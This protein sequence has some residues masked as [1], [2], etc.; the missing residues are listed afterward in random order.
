MN[1]NI[2][3]SGLSFFDEASSQ[4][5]FLPT[6]SFPSYSSTAETM[7]SVQGATKNTLLISNV[8]SRRNAITLRLLT[9]ATIWCM[10]WDSTRKAI[11]ALTDTSALVLSSE[12]GAVLVETS[13][14][15]LDA[16]GNIFASPKDGLCSYDSANSQ[17]YF[18]A[19][20]APMRCEM[21]ARLPIYASSSAEW[22][23]CLTGSVA[24]LQAVAQLRTVS[25]VLAESD[26]KYS[27]AAYNPY[28]G[29]L[30]R[31]ASL[32]DMQ[33]LV[34]PGMYNPSTMMHYVVQGTTTT[35]SD[36]D[37]T[38]GQ[39]FSSQSVSRVTPIECFLLRHSV[40]A[41]LAGI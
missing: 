21:I 31:L 6:P 12:T 2:G 30:I 35:G 9:N 23:P 22:G 18:A 5:Y 17:L 40:H 27:F 38:I 34:G 11:I 13:N 10:K 36:R 4:F 37:G 19:A 8:R 39:D 20:S 28:G 41:L 14:P 15:W 7:T 25:V 1:T 3:M 29:G 24:D 33:P 32:P 26:R 16:F